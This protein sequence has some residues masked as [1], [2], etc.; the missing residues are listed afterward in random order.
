MIEV[1]WRN[2]YSPFCMS[3]AVLL[4]TG[5]A[6]PPP[7][8]PA[9]RPSTQIATAPAKLGAVSMVRLGTGGRRGDELRITVEPSGEYL[10]QRRGGGGASSSTR[11]TLTPQQLQSLTAAF[12]GWE[13]LETV[14]PRTGVTDEEFQIEITYGGKTVVGSDAA[15]NLP[16]NFRAVFR[17]LNELLS[18]NGM[19]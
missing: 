18:A 4:V 13:Q 17:Q 3:M 9:T 2:S 5:C 15:L 7:A 10:I 19:M 11:G 1:V 14:Y 6:T 8:A 12:T 16:R